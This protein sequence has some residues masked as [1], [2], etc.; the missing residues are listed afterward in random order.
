MI[1]LPNNY[2]AW[3]NKGLALTLLL[4]K[5]TAIQC[6]KRA[7]EIKPD[8]A[9]AKDKLNCI[10]QIKITLENIKPAIWR[11]ILV[12]ADINLF[13]LHVILQEV[14]GWEGSHLHHFFINGEYYGRPDPEFDISAEK[15][16]EKK[17][18]L[19]NALK[20]EK[21]KFEY[22][23]DFGDGWRH[24][25]IVEKI[26][27]LEKGKYYPV[28]VDGARACP[29]EDCG[30]VPGYADFLMAIKHPNHARHEEMLEWIGG[31]FDP[32]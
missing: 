1:V 28:C 30:G 11:R 2:A 32:E 18:K 8:Y 21:Q 13:T 23:Y 20:Q 19:K 7:L 31:S 10:Y 25:I 29:P 22:E 5:K 24:E 3:H 9:M 17:V 12:K 15:I 6:Y 26:L 27:P 14:M 4:D 16:N